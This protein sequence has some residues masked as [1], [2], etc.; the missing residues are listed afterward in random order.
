MPIPVFCP[1]CKK[2]ITVYLPSTSTCA[3]C[4]T[5]FPDELLE[6]IR[7]QLNEATHKRP[8]VLTISMVFFAVWGGFVLLGI[9]LP[10]FLN[11][12]FYINGEAVTGGEFL[13]QVGLAW[14]L[15]GLCAVA[16]FIGIFLQSS[17]SRHLI[18]FY[19]S[20]WERHGQSLSA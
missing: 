9:F 3:A 2:A 15:M 19:P 11:G 14:G 17:W 16:I 20:A 12:S 1:T 7:F 18:V 8:I 13:R 5:P 4:G 10:P 6:V